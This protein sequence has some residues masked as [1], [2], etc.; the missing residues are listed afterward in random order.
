MQYFTDKCATHLTLV[1]LSLNDEAID[2]GDPF[3]RMIN[4]QFKKKKKRDVNR[5]NLL[6][7][8]GADVFPY[9]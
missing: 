1:D 2:S 5:L 3:I 4:C 7:M 8:V 6:H 9:G